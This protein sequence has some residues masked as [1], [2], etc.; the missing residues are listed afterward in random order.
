MSIAKIIW[1]VS[2]IAAVVLAF[3]DMGAHGGAILAVLGLASGWFLDHE[4]RRG[5][6]IAA[7]FLM[8]GG[9]AAL[10]AIP[11]IGEYCGMILGS[12]GAVF[13]AASVMAIVRTLL[14]RIVKSNA[15]SATS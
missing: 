11:G 12:L 1:L 3:V 2:A 10:N 4:H 8:A 6:I 14:E 15:A 7:I 13:A 9:S 5:V